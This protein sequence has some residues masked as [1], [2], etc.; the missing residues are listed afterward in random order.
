[1]KDFVKQLCKN[2]T[3]IFA[4]FYSYETSRFF[5]FFGNTFYSFWVGNSFKSCGDGFHVQSPAHIKGGQYIT[6]GERF[7][8]YARLRLECYDSYADYKYTP[9]LVIGNDVT[10]NYNVHVGCVNSI[11]IGNNV[12]FASNVFITDHQHGYIDKRDLGTPPA[13]R[14][15]TSGGPVEIEDNVWIGENVVIMPNVFIGEGCIIG[16]NSVVT[17]SFPKHS[18]LGGVPAKFIKSLDSEN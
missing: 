3:K 15:I 8:S 6:I 16:A 7:V 13:Q 10:M 4:V 12:L 18:V 5:E 9:K 1:M 2:I 11:K 17:K 14:F